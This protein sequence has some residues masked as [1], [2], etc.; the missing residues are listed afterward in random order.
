MNH[1]QILAAYFRSCDISA[2]HRCKVKKHAE[3]VL[4]AQRFRFPS[5]VGLLLSHL[6]CKIWRHI[7]LSTWRS[8]SSV[9]WSWTHSCLSVYVCAVTQ[10][11]CQ[12]A[13]SSYR[14]DSVI[15]LFV[16][17]Q[18]WWYNDADSAA[19]FGCKHKCLFNIFG[20]CASWLLSRVST[21]ALELTP[22]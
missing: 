13:S 5:H 15:C 7:W 1:F 6:W 16:R 20:V 22:F 19:A 4:A 18:C 9:S 10:T 12:V 3:D 17:S 2:R 11:V 8:Q 14:F 21:G